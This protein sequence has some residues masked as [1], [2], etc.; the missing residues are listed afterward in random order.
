MGVRAH[1]SILLALSVGA[2]S[3]AFGSLLNL[4]STS[5]KVSWKHGLFLFGMGFQFYVSLTIFFNKYML[6]TSSGNRFRQ[7]Y[8]LLKSDVMDITNK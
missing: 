8:R 3:L 5:E 7:K 1:L 6:E 4:S 2:V